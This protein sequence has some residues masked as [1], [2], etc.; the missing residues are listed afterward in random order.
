MKELQFARDE[1]DNRFVLRYCCCLLLLARPL[2]CVCTLIPLHDCRK[3]IEML[4]SALSSGT[5]SGETGSLDVSSV[6]VAEL[7]SAL[8]FAMTTKCKTPEAVQLLGTAQVVRELR[9]AI[10]THNFEDARDLLES[11]RGRVLALVAADEVQAIK[12]EVDNWL[13]I[14]ELTAA[15]ASGGAAGGIG[16]MDTSVINVASLDVAI[17]L[18]MRL[19]CRTAE[20]R[21]CLLTAL[22]VRRL[23]AALLVRARSRVQVLSCGAVPCLTVTAARARGVQG[24]DWKFAAQVLE[25]ASVEREN[26]LDA[27]AAELQAARDEMD[28]RKVVF[29]LRVATEKV[30]EAAI[31]ECLARAAKLR[32]SDH[33]DQTVRMTVEKAILA[34]ARLRRCN[35]TLEDAVA[36]V[37]RWRRACAR[38]GTRDSH[39]CVPVQMDRD[40]LLDAVAMAT[41]LKFD[42]PLVS[43]AKVLLGRIRE[44][45]RQAQLALK[46]MQRG[47]L[48]VC[49][50]GANAAP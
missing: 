18:S 21:R 12:F 10:M 41:E 2:V 42:T 27:A 11:V 24:N 40:A 36:R 17:A 50:N 43:R 47:Q 38:R 15:I 39:T 44:L 48:E 37:R 33:P 7:D 26:V 16:R 25:E 46:V 19:G 13:I 22:I 35:E 14:V 30:D 20:A 31:E 29:A 49:V 45:T 34:L 4:L 28:F 6:S 5:A 8:S 23:R 32:L 1:L 3:V 9:V